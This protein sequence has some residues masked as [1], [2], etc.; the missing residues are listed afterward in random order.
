MD[1]SGSRRGRTG[2]VGTGGAGDESA[3]NPSRGLGPPRGPRAGGGVG[4]Q[5]RQRRG[6]RQLADWADLGLTVTMLASEQMPEGMDAGQ[7]LPGHQHQQH[8]HD[9]P[10]ARCG[11]RAAHGAVMSV[12]GTGHRPRGCGWTS[13]AAARPARPTGGALCP[14]AGR[15]SQCYYITLGRQPPAD[16]PNRGPLR[17]QRDQCRESSIHLADFICVHS[18]SSQIDS[19]IWAD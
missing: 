2:A 7:R 19:R 12:V 6:S 15:E 18:R 8:Q 5:T 1:G 9:R 4:G 14:G 10:Q 16:E 17:R 3:R 13:P 11:A